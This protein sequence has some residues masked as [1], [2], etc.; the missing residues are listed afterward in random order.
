MHIAGTIQTKQ[1][2]LP[3]IFCEEDSRMAN[4]RKLACC[5]KAIPKK[6]VNLR[7]NGLSYDEI[8]AMTGKNSG[9]VGSILNGAT[10]KM[11][12]RARSVSLD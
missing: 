7:L 10:K 5:L 3:C 1:I 12:Q 8:A 9:T 4:A 2:A 6:V 11:R